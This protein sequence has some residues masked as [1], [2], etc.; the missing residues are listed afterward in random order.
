M[1]EKKN[2]MGFMFERI[3]KSWATIWDKTPPPAI[4]VEYM[5]PRPVI[6]VN[7]QIGTPPYATRASLF[8]DSRNKERLDRSGSTRRP[9]PLTLKNNAAGYAFKLSIPAVMS[10]GGTL[11]FP[12]APAQLAPGQTVELEGVYVREAWPRSATSEGIENFFL[13]KSHLMPDEDW[14]T[15]DYL[16]QE[17]LISYADY[18]DCPYWTKVV[19]RYQ[20]TA[21]NGNVKSLQFQADSPVPVLPT[22][23]FVPSVAY[24]PPSQEMLDFAAALQSPDYPA[25]HTAFWADREPDPEA[26]PKPDP[27]PAQE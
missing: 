7:W 10:A 27:P 11:S 6:T 14:A 16:E 1:S 17:I 8:W 21:R 20:P 25:A 22:A 24:P 23:E 4:Q 15:T 2:R 9:A 19:L 3:R 18:R 12:A 26:E 13:H 5:P